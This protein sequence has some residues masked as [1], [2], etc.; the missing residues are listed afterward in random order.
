MVKKAFAL[1]DI[2]RKTINLSSNAVKSIEPTER[3]SVT[4]L[5][6]LLAL[7]LTPLHFS[8]F[9]CICQMFKFLKR[10][11]FSIA[12]NEGHEYIYCRD[13]EIGGKIA[14]G[15]IIVDFG[16]MGRLPWATRTPPTNCPSPDVPLPAD[17]EGCIVPSSEAILRYW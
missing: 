5:M 17:S 11:F 6:T 4:F 9:I 8:I 14:D 3:R 13:A 16:T 12:D 7:N 10:F 1:H 2:W 15:A